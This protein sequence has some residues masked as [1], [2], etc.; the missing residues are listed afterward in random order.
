[1]SIGTQFQTLLS[2]SACGLLMGMGYDTYQVFKG[3]GRFPLWLVFFLDLLFWIASALFVFGVLVRVNDG[4]VRFPI[5]F[6]L[7]GGAWL[8]FV[9]GSRRYVQFLH[10]VIKFCQWLY[11]TIVMIIDT[12]LV[13]PVL[14]LYRLILM[15]LELVLSVVTAVLLFFWKIVRILIAPAQKWGHNVGRKMHQQ[16]KGFWADVKKWIRS[17]KKQ[18]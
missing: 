16:G 2:M 1:M 6:G 10:T 4:V 18:D 5:F 8:Y 11:R 17:R 3:K 7:F 9:I 13:R 14:F 15:L 12:V